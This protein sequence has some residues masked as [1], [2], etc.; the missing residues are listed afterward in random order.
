MAIWLS[1]CIAAQVI[2]LCSFAFMCEC[3]YIHIMYVCF[4]MNVGAYIRIFVINK[5]CIFVFHVIASA[6]YVICVALVCMLV[7]MTLCVR[8]KAYVQVCVR[9]PG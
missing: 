9:V 8:V 3:S 7:C 4:C 5:V 1:D 2:T 6:L